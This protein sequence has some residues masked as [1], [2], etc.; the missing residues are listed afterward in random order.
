MTAWN[1]QKGLHETGNGIYSYL[2]PDGSWGWSNSGLIVDGGEALLVDTLFDAPMTRDMLSTMQRATGIAAEDINTVVN[3]HAN[4]DHTHGNGLCSHAEIIASEAGAREMS[5]FGPEQL[6]AMLRAAP[7]MGEVGAYLIEIFG[8]FDFNDVAEKLPTKTFNDKMTLRIGNKSVTLQEVG[9]AHTRGDILVFVDED[10]SVFT[11]DILFIDGTP[12]M[13]A[14]PVSNWLAAC[15]LIIEKRPEVIVPGHGPITD[16]AGVKRVQDYLRYID[17][18]ARKRFDAGM[19]VREA[20]FDISLTD[21]ESWTD[22]ERIAVN[23]DTLYRE[24]QGDT[25][26]P[27]TL[28]IFTLMAEIHRSRRK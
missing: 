7:G 13:W 16:V 15:D 5:A 23:V 8:P 28:Q 18:E 21:F 12:I 27:D 26:A 10:S 19:D 17:Q 9:P 2:Q 3:T 14:G 4:G 6:A 1:Y 22:A 24:Y 25:S 11:G 20:A